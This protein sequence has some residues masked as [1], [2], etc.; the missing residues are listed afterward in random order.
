MK[1]TPLSP[2][3]WEVIPVHVPSD[4]DVARF[5]MRG[6]ADE[7][8][9][10]LRPQ[11]SLNQDQLVDIHFQPPL[12]SHHEEGTS[13]FA[14]D[15]SHHH[16]KF[17]HNTIGYIS[18]LAITLGLLEALRSLPPPAENLDA[19]IGQAGFTYAHTVGDETLQACRVFHCPWK[20]SRGF[21]SLWVGAHTV[22][23][24]FEKKGATSW[25][26][27]ANFTNALSLQDGTVASVFWPVETEDFALTGVRAALLV[28]Q[29][30]DPEQVYRRS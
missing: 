21:F 27:L 29:S 24:T 7:G 17:M 6:Q 15:F 28:M 13:D 9:Y 4:P 18:T 22:K 23:L 26:N 30:W 19:L 1:K 10:T 11:Q 14:V 5:L 25:H 2:L 8:T 12:Q 20:K 16:L 3:N